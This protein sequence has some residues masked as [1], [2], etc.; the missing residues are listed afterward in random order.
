MRYLLLAIPL[1]ILASLEQ[2]CR[3]SSG[4]ASFCD[5]SCLKDSLRFTGGHSL[6]PYVYISASSC[7]ADTIT[8]SYSG[9]GVNRKMGIRDLL[10]N[11]VKINKDYIRVV[12][13]DTAAALVLFNDCQTGRG[14]QL[15]LPF[16]ERDNLSRKSSGINNLDP[17]FSVDESM[18]AYTDRGNIYVED[19]K[20]GK[21]AMMTFG[22]ALD[23]DYDAIHDHIDSVNVTPTRIWV[24]VKIGEDWKELQKSITLEDKVQ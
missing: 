19:I 13:N 16:N 7:D 4:P 24:K 8:W 5:T 21:A 9:M 22:E 2:S 12:F 3:S 14:Y 6:K 10:N 11:P 1:L 20:T 15:K 23:I 18:V 17:K